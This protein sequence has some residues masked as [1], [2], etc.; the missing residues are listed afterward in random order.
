VDKISETAYLVALHRSLESERPD[1]LFYDP[2]A[3]LLVGS[4]GQQLSFILGNQQQNRNAIALRTRVMDDLILQLVGTG[5]VD[6]V[7]NLGAGLDTR[8]YRLPLP[9]SLNWIEVDLPDL[10][11]EKADK[12]RLHR[13]QCLLQ[14]VSLDL[15]NTGQRRDLL[16]QVNAIAKQTLI[17]TEGLVGYFSEAQVIQLAHDLHQQQNLRWWLLEL[18]SPVFLQQWQRSNNGKIYNDYFN[19]GRPAFKFAPEKGIGFFKALGWE[20]FELRSLW[21]AACQFK[22]MS[23]WL[24]ILVPY[25]RRF[26][27][28]YWQ[29]MT[30]NSNIVLLEQAAISPKIIPLARAGFSA[31]T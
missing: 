29:A 5:K 18:L 6:L 25:L 9:A 16:A 22:R 8:P 14:R 28:Q 24:K 7:L 11:A 20:V 27:P 3:R 1:A 26:A 4:R 23:G 21:T 15:A 17:L 13:P 30:Q 2:L 19:C 10:M 31:A 12:L